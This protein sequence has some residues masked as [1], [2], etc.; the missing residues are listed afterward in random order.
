MPSV[1]QKAKLECPMAVELNKWTELFRKGKTRAFLSNDSQDFES[2]EVQETLTAVSHLRHTAVHRLHITARAISQLLDAAVNLAETLQDNLRAAQLDELRFDINIQ[3]KAMELSKNVLEDTVSAELQKI[4]QKRGELE[5]ME[6]ELIRTM[7]DD[8]KNNKTLVGSL[9]EDSV[10]RIFKRK[11]RRE[12]YEQEK[13]DEKQEND[14]EGGREERK[15]PEHEA[16]DEDSSSG[17]ETPAEEKL[18]D[19]D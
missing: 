17:Y 9:L 16:S 11:R 13:E 3:I 7:L 4:Q 6:T 18:G 10:R 8:D 12:G 14:K 15:M 5:R 19:V 2:K 1:L